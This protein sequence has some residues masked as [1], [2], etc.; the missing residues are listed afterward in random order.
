[1]SDLNRGEVLD[2]LL[3]F[4]RPVLEVR[5]VR[6]LPWDSETVHIEMTRN[7]ARRTQEIRS[8]LVDFMQGFGLDVIH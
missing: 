5:D 4:R 1:V 2:D 7:D 3:K 8:Q 6:A